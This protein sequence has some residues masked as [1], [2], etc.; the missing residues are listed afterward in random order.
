MNAFSPSLRLLPLDETSADPLRIAMV[1]PPWI[2]VPPQGYGGIEAVVAL[3][4]EALVARGHGVTLF[5]APGSRSPARVYPLLED[6]H[7]DEIGS[8]L[9]ESDHVACA[10]DQIDAAAER[11]LPFDVLHDHSGFTALAMA[12]RVAVPV[13]HTIHGAF[14]RE[15]ARFYRRHGHKALLV[16]LSRAQVESA[17]AG[18]R[19]AG[20]V[21][22]P[23]RIDRWPL[24]TQKEDYLLWIGRMDPVKGAHRA[25]EATRLAGRTL[26]LAGP[27]QPGQEQ[28]F[29]ERVEP[30]IDDRRVQYVGEVAGVAKQ[31]LYANAAALLM[32]IRWREPF[33]MVMLEAL[34]CGTPVIAFP[35]GA[36][37]EIVIDGENGMLVADE[38][39]MARAI[40]EVDSIDPRRCRSSVAERYDISITVSGYERVYREAIA[41]AHAH[42]SSAARSRALPGGPT[43][44]TVGEH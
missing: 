8:S 30:H 13:V 32:P 9:Y 5:A 26:V 21:P 37:A 35:E 33:G 1:A 16:A 25:I 11:G 15:T 24:R 3:L 23:I 2:P 40:S 6:A 10:W 31:E 39:E 43:A 19:I 44:W 7:P 36:A 12:D 18:V 42:K 22:N 34:A 41:F 27:V 4:C 29:R 20:V 28:Y 14:V 38:A 17:P